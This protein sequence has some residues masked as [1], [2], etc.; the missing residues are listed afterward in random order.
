MDRIA[1]IRVGDLVT[2]PAC[3]V[4]IHLTQL[5]LDSREISSSVFFFLS[6]IV[7]FFE[8]TERDALSRYPAHVAPRSHLF[9]GNDDLSYSVLLRLDLPSPETEM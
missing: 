8:C 1:E 2:H 4:S 6:R 3:L 5:S 7:T 9:T